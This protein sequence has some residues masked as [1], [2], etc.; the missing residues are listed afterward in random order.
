MREVSRNHGTHKRNPAPSTNGNQRPAMP[1]P[2]SPEVASQAGTRPSSPLSSS[3]GPRKSG[4][5]VRPGDTHEC[6]GSR[7]TE[8]RRRAR[9]PTVLKPGSIWTKLASLLFLIYFFL[10]S[11]VVGFPVCVCIR[12]L[13]ILYDNKR[14]WLLHR[15]TTA[16]AYHYNIVNPCIHCTTLAGLHNLAMVHAGKPVI[17]V[18]N[19]QSALDIFLLYSVRHQ[20]P[21]QVGQQ[22]QQLPHSAN[23]LGNVTKGLRT[24]D[25]RLRSLFLRKNN[26]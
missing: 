22:E 3:F 14:R 1:P 9:H 24:S 4:T 26:K 13:H 15:W 19:H 21:L 18:A 2:M 17:F 20:R 7:L 11:L 12:I 23:W 25:S 16:W 6:P 5:E 10:T 8:Q